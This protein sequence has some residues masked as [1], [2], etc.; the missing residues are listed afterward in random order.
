MWDFIEIFKMCNLGR[1]KILLKKLKI[2]SKELFQKGLIKGA[3]A[4]ESGMG[5]YIR[6]VEES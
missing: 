6:E 1:A 4:N 3:L 5:R 2:I